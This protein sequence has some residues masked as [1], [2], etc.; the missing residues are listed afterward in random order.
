MAFFHIPGVV[1]NVGCTEL[2]LRAVGTHRDSDT[3]CQASWGG[4]LDALLLRRDPL[5]NPPPPVSA[6][7][8]VHLRHLQASQTL[9]PGR[10]A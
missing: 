7:A 9:Y 5:W 8:L 1:R 10:L 4:R 6:C 3:V 2:L